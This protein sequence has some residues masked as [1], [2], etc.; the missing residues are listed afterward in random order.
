MT[1]YN[2]LK[3][4]YIKSKSIFVCGGNLTDHT[5]IIIHV[6]NNSIEDECSSW[7]H[8]VA[9]ASLNLDLR[10]FMTCR[11]QNLLVYKFT[12]KMICILNHTLRK[13]I[14]LVWDKLPISQRVW[15]WGNL[16]QMILICF[17]R[18]WCNIYHTFFSA[19]CLF[20]GII[21]RFYWLCPYLARCQECDM[22]HITLRHQIFF[23]MI[24]WLFRSK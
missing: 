22:Q 8:V 12:T 13:H 4:N 19:K 23:F 10:H 24:F 16:S 3:F 2:W 7:W 6:M 1:S 21:L 18:V 5:S 15:Y 14:R 20:W 11:W 9:N 17:L